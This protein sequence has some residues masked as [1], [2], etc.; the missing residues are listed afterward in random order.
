VGL[1]PKDSFQTDS[2]Q[3]SRS[4]FNAS[5]IVGDSSMDEVPVHP[6]TL[7]A[8]QNKMQPAEKTYATF[9]EA[10]A[11]AEEENYDAVDDYGAADAT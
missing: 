11:A 8:M 7:N 3:K 4:A 10:D 5:D 9:E 2:F 1:P 6:M